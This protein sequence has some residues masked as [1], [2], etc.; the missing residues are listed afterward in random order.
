M[1]VDDGEATVIQTTGAKQV[2]IPNVQPG[3]NYKFTVVAVDGENRS[4]PASTATYIE[5]TPPTT[6]EP[7]QPEIE[8]PELD[9]DN[10]NGDNGNGGN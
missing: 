3:S 10:N 9:G 4:E 7:E 6:E 5:G 8:S 2:T 1:Q